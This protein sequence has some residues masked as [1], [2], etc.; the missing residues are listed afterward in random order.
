MVG[1]DAATVSSGNAVALVPLKLAV[2]PACPAETVVT[3][4]FAVVLPA[5]TITVEGTVATATLLLVSVTTAPAVGAA[6]LS[7]TVPVI[8]VPAVTLETFNLVETTVGSPLL[9]KVVPS[10][11]NSG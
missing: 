9:G 2:M 7:V 4:K 10:T 1:S 8:F 3:V 5:A 11:L 6:L